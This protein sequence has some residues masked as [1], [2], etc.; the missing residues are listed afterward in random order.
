MN[1]CKNISCN[2]KLDI[3]FFNFQFKFQKIQCILRIGNTMGILCI[4]VDSSLCAWLQIY[5]LIPSVIFDVMFLQSCK[6]PSDICLVNTVSAA[7]T[8]LYV[9]VGTGSA[10]D[11]SG[12]W[13]AAYH[14]IWTTNHGSGHVRGPGS[15][16]NACP[17]IWNSGTTAGEISVIFFHYVILWAE[18]P[19]NHFVCIQIQLVQPGQ[20]QLQGGQTLQLQG[21]QGQ[22]QQIIIQQPQ[23]AITA[24]QNQVLNSNQ[25]S[26]SIHS[27]KLLNCDYWASPPSAFD[28]TG[29]AD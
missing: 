18:L 16:H 14:I 11:G 27:T 17:C 29:A 5:I 21:Q 19:I 7:I 15:N 24:G 2:I 20:I 13:W 26:N 1:L 28:C 22:P 8:S 9:S 25:L 4:Q 3:V 10:S 23:T 12:E 6:L